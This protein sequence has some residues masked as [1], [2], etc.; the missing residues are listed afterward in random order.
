MDNLDKTTF[1]RPNQQPQQSVPN[2]GCAKITIFDGANDPRHIDLN[3]F[4]KPVISFGREASNDICISSNYVSRR[5]GQFRYMDG[6][7][8]I[9]DIGSKNGL[10]FNGMSI[11]R[12]VLCD[13]DT[14][15][16]DDGV[17]STVAGVLFVFSGASDSMIWKN[18][19]V[20]QYSEI[21]IGRDQGC[22]IQLNHVG[23]SR[24]HARIVKQ[25]NQFFI[26]DNNSTNGIWINGQ[27]LQGRAQ[28]HEKDVITITNS[29]LI[30]SSNLI[31]YCT[32]NK[33]IRVEA[34]HII[35][36]VD[37]GRKIICNDVSMKINPCELVA[38][39]GGSGAGKS[40]IMNCI[41]GYNKPTSGQV[42]VN[43]TELYSNFESMKDIIGYVPQ[44]DIVFDNLSVYDMLKYTAKLR[45]PKDI[46]PKELDA[47]IM[48]V[49]DTVELTQRKDTIIKRLSGGQRKRASIAVELIS[50][51]T[52]FFLD[53]PASGLD[54]GTE[55]NLMRTLKSMSVSG[56]TIIFVTHSTLNLRICDKIV[57]MGA[58]GKL[59]FMGSYDEALKFFEVDDLVDVYNM[60]TD[61]SD[62][63]SQKYNSVRREN[64]ANA[65][66]AQQQT[67][68]K[69]NKHSWMRQMTVL[70]KR[71]LHIIIN[72]KA[73]VLLLLLQAP[74][75]GILISLVVNKEKMF[76]SQEM[77][78]AIFF[79]LACAALW[80]GIMNSIQEICKERVILRREY[81]TGVN[82]SAYVISK[83]AVMGLV[84]LI[85]STLLT[86][87]FMSF[88]DCPSDGVMTAMFIEI[89]LGVF[90]TAYSATA[91]GIFVS[92]L[93]KNA[94][95][96][97]T[98]APILLLPQLLFSGVIFE[99]EGVTETISKFI[100]CRYSMEMFG[101]SV[102]LNKYKN[103]VTMTTDSVTARYPM[104]TFP[105]QELKSLYTYTTE[106]YLEA[107]GM[108]AVFIAA[109]TILAIIVVRGVKNDR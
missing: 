14:I 1:F 105:D 8:I 67:Q 65:P 96:A 73:R 106:H 66:T 24:L 15:R 31:T 50:D 21:T 69:K 2:S 12:R 37:K 82:L 43:G 98:M 7:W 11:P 3:A 30:F 103:A 46:D 20:A 47:V 35:K 79:A 81:M 51:P 109:F 4:G 72:D 62:Y 78:Q 36:K 13:N 45:L 33:G 41:S 22:T 87:S 92:A 54:P 107:V 25:G 48:K 83:M 42:M 6:R 32:F 23:V 85:Q 5:H 53:E 99:L 102:N 90:M 101:T 86:I 75:L 64:I 28:L 88:V 68:K 17:E 93:F 80:V 104:I 57:F 52:L 29:R 60:I 27:R 89:Y 84:C 26:I 55:R 58:G 19:Q 16:I 18:L 59:C 94:D 97:M 56:K 91:M 39:I 71:N 49:I 100:N 44:Q 10:L 76:N 38:I 70:S 74:L 108:L 63:W 9:E 40:T 61:N 77:T 34:S 95:R